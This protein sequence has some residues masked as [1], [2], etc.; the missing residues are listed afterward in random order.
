MD[1][2]LGLRVPLAVFVDEQ[3]C[4]ILSE[5]L[6]VRLDATCGEFAERLCDAHLKVGQFLR[7]PMSRMS[8]PPTE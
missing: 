3:R 7:L 5:C 6:S 4:E 8:L 1:F 2:R